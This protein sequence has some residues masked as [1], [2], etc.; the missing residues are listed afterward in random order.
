MFLDGTCVICCTSE[1]VEDLE[2]EVN[3]SRQ[4][5]YESGVSRENPVLLWLDGGPGASKLGWV[6]SCPGSLHET[7]TVVCWDQGVLRKAGGRAK[8]IS[9]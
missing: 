3:G 8:I 1:H 2:V 6:R 7:C 4:G 5:I 9:S